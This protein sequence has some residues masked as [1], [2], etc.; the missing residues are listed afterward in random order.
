M[1]HL[2][3]SKKLIGIS[4]LEVI[5]VL[6]LSAVLLIA[7]AR[8]TTALMYQIKAGEM[9]DYVTGLTLRALEV[10][11]APAE[12]WVDTDPIA[13]GTFYR[14][15]LDSN[16]LTLVGYGS[17]PSINSCST[18]SEYFINSA[19]VSSFKQIPVCMQFVVRRLNNQY[20]GS[21]YYDIAVRTVYQLP[22][23]ADVLDV[24]GYRYGIFRTT[25]S[26]PGPGPEPEIP[27]CE[28]T[29][30]PTC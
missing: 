12:V 28:L 29:F 9:E 19:D 3:K 2:L 15:S 4:L 27:P 11:K 23:R 14:L 20:S 22:S 10:A 30:P 25:Q 16:T 7:A 6:M 24:K 13:S 18:T 5:A 8:M 1:E 26:G 17:T 21:F